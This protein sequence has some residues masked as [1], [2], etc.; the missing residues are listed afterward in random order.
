MVLSGNDIETDFEKLFQTYGRKER[1][2]QVIENKKPKLLVE[3]I[4]N[5]QWTP[6]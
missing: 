2:I 6:E 4:F 1:L 3:E 5:T